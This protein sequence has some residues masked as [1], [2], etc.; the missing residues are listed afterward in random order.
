MFFDA[1]CGVRFDPEGKGL[2]IITP[3]QVQTHRDSFP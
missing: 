1:P 2:K 3:S